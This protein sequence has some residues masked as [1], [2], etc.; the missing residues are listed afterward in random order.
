M[1]N[2]AKERWRRSISTNIDGVCRMP[3]S[4]HVCRVHMK[5]VQKPICFCLL[6][7]F[8]FPYGTC[9][10]KSCPKYFYLINNMNQYTRWTI[11]SSARYNAQHVEH[12][13]CDHSTITL[14]KIPNELFTP[15]YVYFPLRSRVVLKGSS[16]PTWNALTYYFM[17]T[18]LRI[19]TWM[20]YV[21]F[22]GWNGWSNALGASLKN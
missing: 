2:I 5:Y 7:N 20:V 22:C 10:H 11:E 15:K 16:L 17:N 12:W 1:Q 14:P 19:Q 8:Q 4:R 3:G 18:K 9:G 21:R 13:R 6:L